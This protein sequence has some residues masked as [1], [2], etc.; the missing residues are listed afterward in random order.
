M[1]VPVTNSWM[2]AHSL[3]PSRCAIA[4]CCSTVDHP[5]YMTNSSR[6]S[7]AFSIRHPPR[8]GYGLAASSTTHFASAYFLMKSSFFSDRT[9]KRPTLRTG[10]VSSEGG[11]SSAFFFP[12][13]LLSSSGTA[14]GASGCLSLSTVSVPA[15]SPSVS[16]LVPVSAA[17]SPPAAAC[18]TGVAKMGPSM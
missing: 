16:I 6:S 18:V 11:P 1:S 9:P 3:N 17:A 15:A 2:P 12:S 7:A 8:T 14:A 5:Q 13:A 4:L 10:A